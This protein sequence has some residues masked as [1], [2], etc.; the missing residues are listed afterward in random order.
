[1]RKRLVYEV[2]KLLHSL[3]SPSELLLS[4]VLEASRMFRTNQIKV[5]ESAKQPTNQLQPTTH[6]HIHSPFHISNSKI[7]TLTLPY[8]QIQFIYAQLYLRKLNHL[9]FYFYNN[10]FVYLF[11]KSNWCP[12]LH[13]IIKII[14]LKNILKILKS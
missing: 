3:A 4:T 12:G 2:E 11:Y 10:W 14:K 9:I 7:Y 6:T 5:Y 13:P 8:L 1:M